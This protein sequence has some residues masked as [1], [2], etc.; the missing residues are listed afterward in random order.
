MNY[1]RRTQNP[2]Y[3]KIRHPRLDKGDFVFRLPAPP[4]PV[5]VAPPETSFSL[6]DLQSQAAWG[7]RLEQMRT[8][9]ASTEGFEQQAGTAALK[10]AAWRR[11]ASAFAE[12]DPFS[13]EDDALRQRAAERL[14][15]WQREAAR[16]TPK[17]GDEWTEPAVGMRFRYVPAGTF[18][19]GSP[20]SEE[21]RRENEE[22]HAVTLTRGLWMGETEVTQG[23]WRQ[24]M[25]NNPSGFQDCGETCPVEMVSWWDAVAFA[26]RLS[27]R[28]NLEACYELD[29]V[30]SPGTEEHQCQ[31]ARLRS[32]SCGGF[33]LPTEAEWERAARA[34]TE[35]ATYG[36]NLEAIAWYGGNSGDGTRPVGG[37]L[38]N[39]WGL[40]DMLG[41]VWEWTA[42]AYGPY[43]SETEHDPLTKMG[44]LRV[45]RGGSWYGTAR[46]VRS[47]VRVAWTPGF[48][49]VDRGFRLARGQGE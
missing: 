5:V 48:R 36:G 32:R 11:F 1:S 38:A 6:E 45:I 46:Y 13:E 15:H 27:E 40:E 7:R 49:F 4:V 12:D 41:N 39:D 3:G 31:S 17:S 47:A 33:R 34:L 14:A 25:G 9:F 44:S 2:P 42:D 30:G 35:T 28:A 29:C 23:Q 20:E 26:N 24:L 19:M 16:V 8:A 21:G 43:G 18:Q 10:S 22:L 37:K